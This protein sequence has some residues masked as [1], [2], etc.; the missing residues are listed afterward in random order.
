MILMAG[1]C[2]LW[3]WSRDEEETG[4][5]CGRDAKGV[6]AAGK[7]K[8]SGRSLLWWILPLF[9][10]LG[11][12]RLQADERWQQ[13]CR[14][15]IDRAAGLDVRLEGDV[16]EIE[17]KEK[18]TALKLS[19]VTVYVEGEAHD[20]SD[21]LV[22]V[23]RQENLSF[24]ED[25]SL[26]DRGC[27]EIVMVSDRIP[28]QDERSGNGLLETLRMGMRVSVWGQLESFEHASNP[29]QFDFADY[30]HSLGL[31]GVM[32]GDH[33]QVV[34]YNYSPYYQFIARLR[35]QSAAILQQ[36]CIEEDFGIFQA[37]LLGDKDQLD[38]GIRKLYQRGGI[39]HLLAVSGLH[40]S[41][42]G[43]GCYHLLRKLGLGFDGA[44][45]LAALVTISYGV[46]TGGAASVVRAVTMVLFQIAADKLGRTY[47]LLSAMA[48]AAICLLL[49]SPTLLF[50]AGFQLS[51]GAILAI[52][53][54]NPIVA[55]WLG[56]KRRWAKT[57][58]LSLTIQMVT[59]PMIV[60]HFFEYPVYGIVLNL[61]VIPLMSYVVVSGLAGVVLGMWWLDGGEF[62]IGTGHYVLVI[63]EWLCRRFEQLPEAVW[64]VGRPRLWQIVVYV[65]GWGVILA[66]MYWFRERHR[67]QR[68]RRDVRQY[69]VE[70][71]RRGVLLM[72]IS[73]SFISLRPHAPGGLEAAFLDVG[74]GDGVFLQTRELTVLVDGGST[75]E[76]QLGEQILEP[77]L[78][79]K[80][81]S[82]IDY[83]LVSHAD[84]DHISG[85]TYLLQ[86][87]PDIQIAHLVLPW[88]GKEDDSCKELQE[89]AKTVGTKVFWMKTGN[90]IESQDLVIRCLYAGE[91]LESQESN[92][93]S[94]LLE[95]QYGDVGIL[96]TGDMSTE[97]EM[98]WLRQL[99]Q[100]VESD[101]QSS[102]RILKAAHHGSKYSTSEEFLKE[103]RPE[104][105]VISC[106]EDNSYGHPHQD[107][108]ERLEAVGGRVLV[109]KACGAVMLEIGEE[110]KIHGFKKILSGL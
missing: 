40:V 32:Y 100:S 68:H 75:D 15:V 82:R 28:Q 34:D 35:Q 49:E 50:Q 72:M 71:C 13:E 53:A 65:A 11:M 1:V 64:I 10:V 5:S 42:I 8:E 86:S 31:D 54:V 70:G 45:F 41:L 101:V 89:L 55:G 61:L 80:G 6:S 77:F 69:K 26:T 37:V 81:I 67:G 99:G 96:L 88:R 83:A 102:L 109:T 44:G 9:C 39:A 91:G 104:L 60:Y 94:P 90:R 24:G 4:G 92:D 52:G 76:K 16:W 57:V 29:G 43:L 79:S 14:Q 47:D 27:G 19:D 85:L 22:Y 73:V 74:Q 95:V 33:V 108:L 36:I 93:H 23:R 48:F 110:I 17:K 98:Q 51:F 56:A 20:F 103:I 66:E 106:G 38:D 46:L 105:T 18:S 87:C 84:Q 25:E 12:V 107:T 59:Y 3:I 2:L 21:V 63:Y 30:Y 62:A 78:K 58:V 7:R 97:G